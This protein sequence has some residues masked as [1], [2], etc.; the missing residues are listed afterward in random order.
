MITASG[1]S[2][3]KN[4]INLLKKSGERKSRGLFVI[5]G[6]RMFS[7]IPRDR[8]V[9]VYVSESFAYEN[10]AVLEGMEYEP[11]SDRVFSLMS[12]TKTPQGILAVVKMLEYSVSDM[13]KSDTPRIVVLE[14]I[15]DPGNLGTIM[16]SAEGAGATGI[17]MSG[18]TVDIYNPKTIRS[19]MGSLFR[20]PFIYSDNLTETVRMLKS[21]NIKIFAAHLKGRNYYYR[22]NLSCPMALLIGNEGNGLTP[23]LT[24]EADTLVKIPMEGQLESLNA[25]ISTAVILYEAYRQKS[26]I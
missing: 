26:E 21:N 8:I 2:Q 15:Q 12:D 13:L 18:D 19:T 14:N 9:K 11:V 22:E 20:M 7:E 23:G 16:R 25:A 24:K 4:V 6:I 3:V 1:N 17:I 5:E 10:K